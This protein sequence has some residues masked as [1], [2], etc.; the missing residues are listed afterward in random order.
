[1]N[2]SLLL[3]ITVAQDTLQSAQE[4]TDAPGEKMLS[5][6]ELTQEGGI[7]MIILA[8][9]SIIAVYIFVERFLAI[10]KAAKEDVNFM[11]NIRDFIHNGKIDAAKA[12]C[13][14]YDN[15]IARMIEKGIIR[16]GKP[17]RD[18]GTA[19]ENIGQLEIDQLEKNI[20]T[21]KTIAGAAPMLGFLGTVIGMIKAFHQMYISGNS[22]EISQLSGGIMQAMVT[23]VA[24]LIVGIVAF[25]G[26]NLL[27][28]RVTRIV[29]KMQTRTMEFMD[30]LEEPA[31]Q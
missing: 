10:R 13:K 31:N 20:N 28:A 5:L 9:L 2:H 22:I 17:L 16:I 18:I 15:P 11:N 7:I 24:G 6:W 27:V 14:S 1:M 26:Y 21:L 3:Q 19:I 4:I 8:I 23:T 29:F 25:I 30:L 12:L